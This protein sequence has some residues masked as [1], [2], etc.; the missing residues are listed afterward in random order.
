MTMTFMRSLFGLPILY[1]LA[2]RKGIGL[3][4]TRREW[5]A[6]LP[7]GLFGVFATTIL[8]YSSFSLIKV[9]MA[10][11]LH[12]IFPMLVMLTGTVVFRERVSWWKLASLLLGLAGVAAF[13]P[14]SKP[15]EL[16]GLILALGS[17]FTY[18]GLMVAIERTVIRRMPVYQFA[19]YTSLAACLA[20]LAT[21]LVTGGLTLRL[22]AA[23][24]AYSLAVALMVTVGAFTLLNLAIIRCGATTTAIVA[25]L[26]PLTSVLFGY[27]FLGEQVTPVNLLGFF[28]ILSGV[29]L[30]SVFTSKASRTAG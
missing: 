30:V 2:R 17:G 14:R 1:A 20:S 27:L 28:L 12:Y 25:M 26:E 18:A 21:G 5:M 9:G 24:W 16:T 6:V 13:V 15:G 8:L 3:S 23:A 7:V 11:V 29:F 22:S 10:T 19:F 4:L